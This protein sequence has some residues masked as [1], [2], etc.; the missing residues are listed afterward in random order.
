MTRLVYR[1]SIRAA[2][3]AAML[4]LANPAPARADWIFS[5]YLG[6]SKTAANTVTIEPTTGGRFDVGPISYET[7][8]F[9]SPVYYGGRLTFFFPDKPWLGVGIE[10]THNKAIADVTQLVGIDGAPPAPLA[11]VLRRL[12]LSNGLNFALANVVVRRPIAVGRSVDRLAL[13]AYG[14]LGAAVPHVE[15]TFA[16]E[17][18]FEY[19]VTGLG[20]QAG[21]G[22]EWR[23]AS[24]LSAIADLRVTGGRQR[25]DMKTGTLTGAFTST[26][27]DFGIGWHFGRGP[28]AER[29][30]P[31]TP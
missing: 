9:D 4:L 2:L 20:W 24:G 8:A 14:G 25:L 29:Q 19:Q 21:G 3:P 26:Q 6:A 30:A 18:T 7:F 15:T 28:A 5:A 13:M 16:G 12:E 27:V 31:R 10:F 17:E 11:D 23:I 22:A 1:L